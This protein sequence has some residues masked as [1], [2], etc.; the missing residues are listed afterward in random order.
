M[1]YTWDIKLPNSKTEATKTRQFL[2]MEKGTVTRFELTFPTGCVGLVFVHI[3][4][5]LH[6]VY[7]KNPLDR[8]RG[9]GTT[10]IATDEYEIK[11]PPF[12]LEFHGWNTDDT[13]DHTVTVRIQLVPAKEI[14]HRV[15]GG[16]TDIMKLTKP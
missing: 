13:Y 6:Q 9:N 15:I 11:E 10:I 14:I 4:H 3:D 7:P 16:L 8:L 1:F 2:W 12:A 5:A